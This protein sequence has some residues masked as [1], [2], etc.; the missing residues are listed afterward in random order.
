MLRL[1]A[2]VLA[3]DGDVAGSLRA[4]QLARRRSPARPDPV[5]AA[6]LLCIEAIAH[7]K[8]GR[9]SEAARL[10]REAAQLLPESDLLPE[11]DVA[12]SKAETDAA[13]V[14]G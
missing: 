12:I 7:A 4:V 3:Y 14:S 11:V 10:R 13:P 2:Y 9:T 8:L 5:F 1:R 6:H